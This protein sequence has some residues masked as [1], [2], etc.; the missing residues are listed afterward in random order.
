M[1]KFL[2]LITILMLTFISGCADVTKVTRN[3]AREVALNS[4]AKTYVSIPADGRYGEQQYTGSGK[5]AAGIVLGAFSTKM[6][7]VDI[8]EKYEAFDNALGTAKTGGYQYLISPKI[9]H[10]EDRNTAWSG[11]PS[12]ASINIRIIDVA[13]GD[14]I[15]SVVIDSRSSVMRMTDPSPE[16]ALP[17]PIQEYVD[18]LTFK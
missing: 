8:G 18:S 3:E 7:H 9:I 13:S 1:N 11:R 16:D 5:I 4:K 2:L 10:W 15:D 17:A 12:K 14:M 6:L